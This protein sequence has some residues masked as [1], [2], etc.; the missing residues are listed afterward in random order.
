MVWWLGLGGGAVASETVS[1]EPSAEERV[2]P[3]RFPGQPTPETSRHWELEVLYTEGR[4][5]E[6]VPL[7]RAALA[8]DPTDAEAAWHLMRFLYELG[9]QIPRDDKSV[10]K[11]A[12][13]KEMVDILDRAVEAHPQDA[14]L[15]FARGI[16]VGRY[17]TT[18]GVLASLFLAKKVEQDWLQT[19]QSGFVYS[20]LGG[21]ERLPCDA[22]HGLGI[23]YRLVPDWW[24]IQALAGTRGSL[25]KSLEWHRKADEACPDR[26]WV[27]KELAATE[28]C[29]AEREGDEAMRQRALEHLH[30]AVAL[31][32][33]TTTERIDRDH[34]RMLLGDPDLACSYSRD[35]QQDLERE[36]LPAE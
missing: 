35:G 6:G 2:Y 21:E 28:L 5:R 20:S 22:Y 10:D 8:T 30:R 31:P 16:A 23:F 9:E 29:V 27:L 24:M 19:A 13:Y 36:S 4:F 12:Y 3:Q 32:V 33:R 34:S 17:G 11:V 15:R 26:V 14:H 18:R 1:A 25:D 7:A